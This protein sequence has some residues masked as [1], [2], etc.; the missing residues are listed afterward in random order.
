MNDREKYDYMECRKERGGC[1][2]WV[3][4]AVICVAVWIIISYLIN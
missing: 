3:F 4:G 2:E 1:A